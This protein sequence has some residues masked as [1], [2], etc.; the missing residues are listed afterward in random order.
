[1][2]VS[3]IIT[4]FVVRKLQVTEKFNFVRKFFKV[5]IHLL[6]KGHLSIVILQQNCG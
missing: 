1:M 6:K 4:F 3:C 2:S 5:V